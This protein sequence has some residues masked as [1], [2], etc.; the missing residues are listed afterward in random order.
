MPFMLFNAYNKWLD[1]NEYGDLAVQPPSME[2]CILCFIVALT[3]YQI[4]QFKRRNYLFYSW[5]QR[6]QSIVAW[7][8]ADGQNIMV[9]EHGADK[10]IYLMMDKKQR[11]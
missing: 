7:L 9:E 4:E 11:R 6:V 10:A 5:F 3:K 8:H 1:Q 2:C